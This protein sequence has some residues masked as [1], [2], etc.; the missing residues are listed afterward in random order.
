MPTHAFLFDFDGVIAETENHHVAAWQRTLGFMGLQ[1]ADDV[2]MRAM[3]DDDREFLTALFAERNIPIDRVDDWVGR[4]QELTV[5][6]LRRAPRVYPGVVEVV[7]ALH[8]RTRLAVVSGT[9]RENVEA[10]LDAAGLADA[11]D[12]IVAKEDVTRRKP[13]P[14]AYL[15]ALEKLRLPPQ[16]VV[17]LEDSPTGIASARA[18]GIGRIIAVGHRRP[19]G[20]WTAGAEYLDAIASMAR[21]LDRPGP[22]QGA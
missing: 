22:G 8:G 6:L 9:W 10:V 14:E 18:A 4:K 11:F 7:R 12:L 2:A 1:V 15:V 21:A 19:R 3:E 20:D 16:S 17:V 5:E 13:D